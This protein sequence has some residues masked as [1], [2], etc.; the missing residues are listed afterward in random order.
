M[1]ARSVGV[2]ISATVLRIEFSPQWLAT[3]NQ[4]AICDGRLTL[5]T[6]VPVTTADV[7]GATSVYFAPLTGN[8]IALFDG[9]KW[10]V[11]PFTQITL[12]LG[13]LTSGLP[14]DIFIYDNAGTLTLELTAWTNGTTRA[15]ALVRQD[16]VLSKTGALTRRY[17]G[18]LYTT[19]TTQTEDSMAKRLLDNYYN[20]RW[21]PMRVNEAT[22]TWTY[23]TD[24]YQQAN[25]STA[26]QLE[27]MIGVLED[28]IDV[29]LVAMGR[30]DDASPR[31]REVSIGE[32]STTTPMTGVKMSQ[33]YRAPAQNINMSV[34]AEVSGFP[35][36]V[37]RHF[38]AWLEKAEA[39]GVTT[40]IGDNG[41]PTAQQMG[42]SGGKWG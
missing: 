36:S 14:Y 22:N 7:T 9:N 35:S 31:N 16:G 15:T 1:N 27:M 3:G 5:T 20:R 39:T 19:S 6:A 37:G 38:Y 40:W 30:N 4:L 28:M 8:R 42:I 2:A 26:N 29:R 21:R 25:A 10:K 11:Y 17:L 12:A 34:W 18:A 33:A 13:T 24:T 23:S 41:A 32:D